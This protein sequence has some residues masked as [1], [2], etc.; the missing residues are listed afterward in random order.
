MAS[1]TPKNAALIRVTQEI[2]DL[3]EIAVSI[4]TFCK[5]RGFCRTRV[6]Q[7]T[8][9]RGRFCKDNAK[10]APAWPCAEAFFLHLPQ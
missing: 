7:H 5:R 4:G 1:T 8:A 2:S 3:Q 9:Y 6:R 10:G